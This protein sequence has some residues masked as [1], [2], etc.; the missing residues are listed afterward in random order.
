MSNLN[1]G[2]R[3]ILNTYI[4]TKCLQINSEKE[5]QNTYSETTNTVEKN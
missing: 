5:V 3:K 4:K 2:I 1:N